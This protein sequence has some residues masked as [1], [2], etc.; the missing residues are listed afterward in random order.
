MLENNKQIKDDEPITHVV[1]A[2]IM[3]D[4]KNV[5]RMPIGIGTAT[6]FR[7]IEGF[8]APEGCTMKLRTFDNP[9]E[10]EKYTRGL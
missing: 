9:D 10:A 6:S 2:D 1:V 8:S 7:V 5:A 4:G 3:K